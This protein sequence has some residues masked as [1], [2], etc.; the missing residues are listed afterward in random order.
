MRISLHALALTHLATNKCKIEVVGGV[1][2]AIYATL[3]SAAC[4]STPY[5]VLQHAVASCNA[6]ARLQH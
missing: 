6:L 2:S 5:T 4:N 3:V 1:G